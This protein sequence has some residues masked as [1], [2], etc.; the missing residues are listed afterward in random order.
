MLHQHTQDPTLVRRTGRTEHRTELR[1]DLAVLA[2]RRAQPPPT[3]W[4]STTRREPRFWGYLA[5]TAVL[6]TLVPVTAAVGVNIADSGWF[7]VLVAI[8]ISAAAALA[9]LASSAASAHAAPK[10]PRAHRARAPR[11]ARRTHC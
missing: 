4:R 5:L 2:L 7:R 9:V 1:G 10:T 8:A 3:G 11:R 6:A